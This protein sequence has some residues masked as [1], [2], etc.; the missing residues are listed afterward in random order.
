MYKQFGRAFA[1]L[2]IGPGLTATGTTLSTAPVVD[3][4]LYTG[5]VVL[6]NPNVTATN[7]GLVGLIGTASGTLSDLAGTFTTA[8]TTALMLEVNRPAGGR[9]FS[10]QLRQGTS[11][12]HGPIYIFGV[13]PREL[14]VTTQHVA[15]LTYKQV[16]YPVTGT[17]TSS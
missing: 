11:G 6:C 1:L 17:A 2:G 13:G 10:A 15:A 4:T 8:Q 12:R 7:N 16:N 9:F 14:P 5:A 3:L